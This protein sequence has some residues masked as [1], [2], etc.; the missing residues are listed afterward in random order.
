MVYPTWV[1]L[2]QFYDPN[3]YRPI[4]QVVQLDVMRNP[5]TKEV[6][7]W[8]LEGE[9]RN[10]KNVWEFSIGPSIGGREFH[11]LIQLPTVIGPAHICM[12]YEK[13]NGCLVDKITIF[14]HRS[15]QKY[16]LIIDLRPPEINLL[17]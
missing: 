14:Y 10:N 8:L 2:L 5:N 4:S 16:S 3:S 9:D 11:T 15:S 13:S 1:E 12:D 7:N 17:H 6:I